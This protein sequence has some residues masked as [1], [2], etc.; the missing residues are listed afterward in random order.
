M[1]IPVPTNTFDGAVCIAVIH[2]MSTEVSIEKLTKRI[3]I[4]ILFRIDD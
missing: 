3:R 1:N 2:H 4:D